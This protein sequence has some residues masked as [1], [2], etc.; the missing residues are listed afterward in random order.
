[1][2]I[3]FHVITLDKN[4][5]MPL[6]LASQG[7]HADACKLFLQRGAECGI[8]NKRG[9]TALSLARKSIKSKFAER[10]FPSIPAKGEV[11]LM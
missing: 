8:A 1:M 6:M 5:D 3:G 4:G 11:H 9:E 10:S 2:K 7:G